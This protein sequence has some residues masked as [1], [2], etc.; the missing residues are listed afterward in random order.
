[1]HPTRPTFRAL[2]AAESRPLFFVDDGKVPESYSIPV[3]MS[4][5]RFA[6]ALCQDVAA[7]PDGL[8]YP[9]LRHLHLTAM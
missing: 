4:E 5:L 3:T 9:F 7:V 6:L 8:S 2:R 1:M